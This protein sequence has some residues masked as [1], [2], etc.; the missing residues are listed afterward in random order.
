MIII[1]C[2][3]I[4]IL[5]GSKEKD[6]QLV[7]VYHFSMPRRVGL[8]PACGCKSRREMA[9]APKINFLP[10]LAHFVALCRMR[11]GCFFNA[12]SIFL[13]WFWFFQVLFQIPASFQIII[14]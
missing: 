5:H 14:V 3:L 12:T 11:P 6:A 9:L 2:N 10:A 7:A 8:L 1:D 4:E 13:F